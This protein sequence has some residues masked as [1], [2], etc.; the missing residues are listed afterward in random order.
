MAFCKDCDREFRNKNALQQHLR[1]SPKHVPTLVLSR[2]GHAPS[3][4]NGY[5]QDPHSIA[6]RESSKQKRIFQH[7]PYEGVS[8]D[9]VRAVY[10]V[11]LRFRRQNASLDSIMQISRT[12]LDITIVRALW[13]A[14]ERLNSLDESPE[15]AR[16]RAEL[17]KERSRLAQLAEDSF[18]QRIRSHGYQ[19]ILESELRSQ[20]KANGLPL[21]STPD[22][23]CSPPIMIGSESCG[24]LEYK[25]YFGF[26]NNPFVAQSEKRQ[27]RKY[28]QHHGPGA[29]VY[30]WDFRVITRI[31]T[32]WLS[33]GLQTFS[34][35]LVLLVENC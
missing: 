14:A 26:P 4:G 32:E 24:W 12:S 3:G 29:M 1:D 15:Q 27:L 10:K 25:D 5:Q 19:A 2:D 28:V 6:E 11:A 35:H 13:N 9:L 16:L 8:P 21:T 7:E 22:M 34:K 20:A 31:L 23:T 17:H 18:A 33:S 30:A